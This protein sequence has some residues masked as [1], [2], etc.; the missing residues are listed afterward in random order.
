MKLIRYKFPGT[1]N[2]REVGMV[3]V[4]DVLGMGATGST[5]SHT[6]KPI[7]ALKLTAEEAGRILRKWSHN[8]GV[9]VDA[10][11]APDLTPTIP[12]VGT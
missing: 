4:T 10:A 2:G 6:Y 3:Y 5:F 7:E 8:G 1:T 12:I 11:G 9:I